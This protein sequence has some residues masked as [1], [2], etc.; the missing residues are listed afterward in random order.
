VYSYVLTS[1]ERTNYLSELRQGHAI[2]GVSSTGATR[3]LVVG[4]AK[5]ET[6]PLI[7]L[8]AR[9]AEGD[10]ASIVLQNDWHVRMLGPGGVVLNCTELKPGSVMLGLAG[11][12]ARHV[13][14]AI[15]EY[16]VEQ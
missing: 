7:L 14:M 4:R 15:D 1:P 2:I 9:T 6:R 8:K 3:P 11:R 5:I 12:K 10:Q 13:G 16:C